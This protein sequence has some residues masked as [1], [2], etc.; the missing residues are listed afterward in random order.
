MVTE[1]VLVLQRVYGKKSESVPD[2]R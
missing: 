2:M 1:S